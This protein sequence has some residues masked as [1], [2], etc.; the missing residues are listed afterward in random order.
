MFVAEQIIKKF[1]PG[2]WKIIDQDKLGG[3]PPGAAR[4]INEN[5]PIHA[6]IKIP[7]TEKKDNPQKGLGGNL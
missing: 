1:S 7:P 5:V 3:V 4:V 2:G 6:W